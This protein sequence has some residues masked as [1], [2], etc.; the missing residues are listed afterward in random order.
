MTIAALIFEKLLV[1]FLLMGAG[2]FLAYR[3]IFTKEITLELSKLLTRFVAPSLFISSFIS[4]EF[5]WEKLILLL[6]VIASAFLLIVIRI[7][8]MPLFLPKNRNTDKY[9]ILFANV[10][11]MGTPL[12]LAVGGKEAV[13]FISGFVVA[14]QIMQWTY[15]IYLISQ[16]K[17][18]INLRGVF[19]NPAMI[20]T[21]IGILLFLLPFKLPVV[22]TD[23]IDTFAQLNTPLSTLVL[24][25]YFYKTAFK[26]IFLYPAA[27]YTAFLRLF[28]TSFI[29]ILIIWLL[30]FS[31]SAV[32]LALTIAVISPAAMNTALLSQVYGGD[33][34]YGSR[35][36]LLTTVLSLVSIPIMVAVASF[37]Y[38]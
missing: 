1:L 11:F 12:A 35:L 26:D 8:L 15:G 4:Q 29:S 10:G 23:A 28:M 27:Y 22:L 30:P 18:V 2:L 13:F 25:S 14:N 34:E 9:A 7:I 36:V 16:D 6:A 19:I 31:L 21:V 17:S 5:S 24:G 38:L 20:A 37:L 3:R 32:K 33:Y